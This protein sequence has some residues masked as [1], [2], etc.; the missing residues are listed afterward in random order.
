MSTKISNSRLYFSLGWSHFNKNSIKITTKTMAD[1]MPKLNNFYPDVNKNGQCSMSGCYFVPWVIPVTH[2]GIEICNT[3]PCST[4]FKLTGTL[5]I[6]YLH[7]WNY[8]FITDVSLFLS[9]VSDEFYF[10]WLM[11]FLF[12][13]FRLLRV[14]KWMMENVNVLKHGTKK[15]TEV[16]YFKWGYE[17]LDYTVQVNSDR[18]RNNSWIYAGQGDLSNPILAGRDQLLE[19]QNVW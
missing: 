19:G 5:F 9:V 4:T 11:L 8:G 2:K 1:M 6:S 16:K 10:L 3:V 13:L 7:N 18:A 17:F 12:I 14:Q 15:C